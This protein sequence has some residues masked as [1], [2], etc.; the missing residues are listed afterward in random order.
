MIYKSIQGVTFVVLGIMCLFGARTEGKDIIVLSWRCE[1]EIVE[2]SCL[3]QYSC[4]WDQI[5]NIHEGT[6]EMQLLLWLFHKFF[7]RL[8]S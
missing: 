1:I 2:V 7:L 4:K 3:I 5:H 8:H 6:A